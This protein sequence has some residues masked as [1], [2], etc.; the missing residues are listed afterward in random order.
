MSRLCSRC[1]V[2]GWWL[3]GVLILQASVASAVEPAAAFLEG[4][5]QRQLYDVALDYLDAAAK[6]PAVPVE[7][8]QSLLYERGV[9]LI[10][11]ARVNKDWTFKEKQLDEG[12]ATLEK[13]IAANPQ[14]NFVVPA[15]SQ[16]TTVTVERARSRLKRS[17][18][19]TGATKAQLY[20]EARE[21]YGQALKAFEELSTEINNRL[22]AYPASIN[23]KAEPK[24][25]AER[26]QFRRNALDAEIL[27]A[28]TR[29][30]MSETYEVGAK[31]REP[32]L[33][34]AAEEYGEIYAKYRS[35][36]AGTYA[37]MY[38]ARCLQK[39]GRH[40]EAIGFYTELLANPDTEEAFR[41]LRIKVSDLA[42]DSWIELKLY[43]EVIDKTKPKS[44]AQLID[45]ARK[46]EDKSDAFMSIRLGMA[47]A[48]KVFA[49]ELK[50]QDPKDPNAKRL[51][52]DGGKLVRFVSKNP[53]PYEDKAKA[54]L[55]DFGGE[56]GEEIEGKPEPKNFAEARKAALDA[57]DIVQSSNGRVRELAERIKK[58]TATN[59]IG[60]V[61][62]QLDETKKQA[63]AA[64]ED[65]SRYLKRSLLLVEPTTSI[66]DI[67]LMRYLLCFLA[68]TNGN[69]YEVAVLGDYIAR[70]YPGAN[71][72]RQC[73]G[74]TLDAYLKLY[75]EVDPAN[76]EENKDF[77]AQQIISICKYLSQ[78]WPDTPEAARAVNTLIP[79]MIKE[80][81]LDDAQAYLDQIP[82][83]APNRGPAELRIG[84]SLWAAFYEGSNQ[85]RD[86]EN[87]VIKPE[88]IDPVKKKAEL[89]ALKAK[90]KA[91]LID[92]VARMQ[93]TGEVSL[94]TVT[95]V[96]S[97]AQIYVD[98]NESAKATELLEDP[99][100]GALTLARQ[101]DPITTQSAGFQEEIY[102]TALRSYIS[103]LS[104]MGTNSD[105]VIKKAEGVM[106]SLDEM[107]KNDPKGQSK[108]IGIY[109]GLAKDLQ[110]QMELADPT[111]KVA[112]G[113]GF[114]AFLAQMSKKAND[115]KTLNWVAE[116]YRGMGES[117]GP[118]S[119]GL[120]SEAVRYFNES[121]TT[122]NRILKLNTDKPGTIDRAMETL[123]KLQVARIYRSTNKY[124]EAMNLFDDILKTQNTYIPVQV[125]A[126][127][128]YQDWGAQE[129]PDMPENYQRA[130]FGARPNQGRNNIWGWGQLAQAVR[131]KPELREVFH[132]ARYNMAYCRYAF[133]MKK[134]GD[135]KKTQ[136]TTAKT[137]IAKMYGLFPELGGDKWKP[138][139]EALLK[140]IQKGLGEDPVGLRTFKFSQEPT[141]TVKA[142]PAATK[143]GTPATTP[144]PAPTKTGTAPAT[145]TSTPPPATKTPAPA[146]N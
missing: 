9:T 131:Q 143:T 113:K 83:D 121:T 102:K 13:F 114:E 73:G 21:F 138:Q 95:A 42:I 45:S 59:E 41:T 110:K 22:K 16:L 140:N 139:Y 111:L 52:Q 112:L 130:I 32:T 91:I 33:E 77:E 60:E 78:R 90:A 38:Q 3:A 2:A 6:N 43:L 118:A 37:R 28:A 101:K 47:R 67:N 24:K 129:G 128:T 134:T 124:K 68:Y 35:L 119:K 126:A 29:E 106:E 82:Q 79:F 109:V 4:L 65:A 62:K 15:R 5:R 94:I 30:E 84:Q 100:I 116:T 58:L 12:Q 136:L 145:K 132:E 115:V 117:F 56:S 27:H 103:S 75:A 74:W 66:D 86:Y 54:M 61:Q 123:L 133:A 96:W 20:V 26:Q 98:T 105:E 141:E 14:S 51:M 93:A 122:F 135:E 46:H 81:R 55:P 144:A 146:K 49:D 92:G 10:E 142:T 88:G 23:E 31:E 18:K 127:K 7:F 120:S 71:G 70:R 40:K 36:L 76:P 125:E 25:F 53:G 17:E 72:A 63:T 99:K 108:L 44:P 64:K 97:L 34:A 50:A 137:D 48:M 87:A 8:K 104:V 89:E 69:H 85:L 19:A 1:A 57:I 11:G 80:R 107:Y 39:L